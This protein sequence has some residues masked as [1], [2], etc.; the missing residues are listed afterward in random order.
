MAL[1]FG[2]NDFGSTMIEE[3]VVAAT[4]VTFRLSESEIKHL[5]TSAGYKAQRR[6]HVYR[7]LEGGGQGAVAPCPLPQTPSPNPL[8]GFPATLKGG[9]EGSL[10]G[11]WGTHRSPGPPLNNP[12][13]AVIARV[14]AHRDFL[15]KGVQYLGG[16]VYATPFG[17]SNPVHLFEHEGLT[18]AVLSRHGEE[19]YHVGAAFVNDRANLYAL[20]DLGV[21]KSWPG[22][23][24]GPSTRPWRRAIWRCRMTFWM[25]PGE[26]RILFFRGGAWALCGRTRCFARSC[27]RR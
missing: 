17:A 26:G 4:G 18:F 5:I 11:G 13:L 22:V 7:L 8:E 24:R 16:E 6:D 23:R 12:C 1:A 14:G 15:A 25:K 27:A 20:K 9:E 21:E 10:R 3:N 2:A 19:G